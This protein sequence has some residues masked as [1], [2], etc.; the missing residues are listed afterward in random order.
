MSSSKSTRP[1][2]AAVT[3]SWVKIRLLTSFDRMIQPV[4]TYTVSEK[5]GWSSLVEDPAIYIDLKYVEP[6]SPD[7]FMTLYT[8]K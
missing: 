4:P 6:S 7:F 5:S 3:R 1:G 2:S 8:L